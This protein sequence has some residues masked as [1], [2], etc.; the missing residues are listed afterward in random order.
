M[1]VLDSDNQEWLELDHLLIHLWESHLLRLKVIYNDRHLDPGESARN[2]IE[3]LFPEA[4]AR[5]IVDFVECRPKW[6]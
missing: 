4:M 2:C 3:S 6:K 5:G 1:D